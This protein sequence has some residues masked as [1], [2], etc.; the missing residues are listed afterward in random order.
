MFPVHHLLCLHHISPPTTISHTA[1][2]L[3][4]QVLQSKG[5]VNQLG[6]LLGM[7]FSYSTV[8]APIR[9]LAYCYLHTDATMDSILWQLEWQ[10][11]YFFSGEGKVGH[12]LLGW[13]RSHYDG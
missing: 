9:S 11:N 6:A 10:R 2:L 12:A 8:Q 7:C 4:A 13:V 5:T 1:P 3:P